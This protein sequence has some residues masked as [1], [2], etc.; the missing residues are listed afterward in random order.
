MS[1]IGRCVFFFFEEREPILLVGLSE[2][3][4]NQTNSNNILEFG[5]LSG[6]V[7]KN[8]VRVRGGGGGGGGGGWGGY[9]MTSHRL[10]HA[11][12]WYH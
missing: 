6:H 11:Y 10:G 5:I 12:L 1:L 8:S 9:K 4:K 2:F 7:L 3:L